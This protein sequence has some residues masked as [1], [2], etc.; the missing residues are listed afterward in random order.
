MPNLLLGPLRQDENRTMTQLE[1]W[2]G[3]IILLDFWASWCGPCRLSLPLLNAYY[4]TID[5]QQITILAIN[6]DE[7][8]AKGR[9]FLQR[10]PVSYTVLSD[11][12]GKAAAAFQLQGMPATFLFDQQGI[13]RFK[14][15]GFKKSHLNEIKQQV[16]RLLTTD[17]QSLTTTENNYNR[18][19]L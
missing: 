4:Q 14:S 16:S 11:P 13:L 3:K 8:P 1:H 10:F 2:Q 19:K 12:T 15:T 18:E 9:A 17:I 6:V 7:N 5:H